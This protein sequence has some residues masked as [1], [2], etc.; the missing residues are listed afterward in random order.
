MTAHPLEAAIDLQ[1]NGAGRFVGHTT[2]EYANMVGPFGGVTAAAVIRAVE[3][4]PDRLGEPLALTINYLAAVADGPFDVVVR[5]ART[6]RTNQ[7]WTAELTQSGEVTTT[8]TVLTGI[9]RQAWS[10]TEAAMPTVL[11]PEMSSDTTFPINIAWMDNYDIRYVDGPPPDGDDGE[12]PSSTTTLWV[13]HQPA[14]SGSIP[15]TPTRAGRYGA[16]TERYWSPP[17]RSPTTRTERRRPGR[18]GG[19]R[20]TARRRSPPRHRPGR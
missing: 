1:P 2:P 8:A 9:R 20:P 7:H 6:N 12:S 17:T 10:D 11:A 14:G 15:D 13:R 16:A 3:Q 4:H 19:W 5:A 18:D